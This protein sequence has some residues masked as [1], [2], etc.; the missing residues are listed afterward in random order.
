MMHKDLPI[1]RF[2]L[3]LVLICAQVNIYFIIN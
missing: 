3:V 1:L 2:Y